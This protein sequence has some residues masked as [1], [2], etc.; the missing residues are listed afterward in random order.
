MAW[1]K[2]WCEQN[3]FGPTRREL[4]P[5][6]R[7]VWTDYLDL[8]E[9]SPATGKVCIGPGVGYTQEQLAELL[10]VPLEVLRRAEEKM[11]QAGKISMGPGRVVTILNWPK[12]QSEYDR[13]RRWRRSPTAPA[14]GA[15]PSATGSTEP[16]TAE[17]TE[18]STDLST[19]SSTPKV[20]PQNTEADARNQK[21]EKSKSASSP[22]AGEIGVPGK[23]GLI[24]ELLKLLDLKP[25][26]RGWIAELLARHPGLDLIFEA[27]KMLA[28]CK[29]KRI[30]VKRPRSRF[31]NWLE[32]AGPKGLAHD[33]RPLGTG[34]YAHKYLR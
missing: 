19:E 9:L 11:I 10:V 3:I 24:Q 22:E 5:A 12:Y 30:V 34:K 4:D 15:P 6:E 20:T 26:D 16:P 23:E 27:K 32:H 29:D 7:S 1:R 31:A 33:R 17:S 8:A 14:E 18:R 2:S 28:Y 21:P 25:D 13:W